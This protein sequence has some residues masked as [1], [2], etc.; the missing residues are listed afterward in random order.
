MTNSHFE[1]GK[2]FH[3]FVQNFVLEKGNISDE[4][5]RK[6][7][8]K[9]PDKSRGSHE[10]NCFLVSPF[11]TFVL[12]SKPRSFIEVTL[13][14]TKRA[15]I[16]LSLPEKKKFVVIEIKTSMGSLENIEEQFYDMLM[17]TKKYSKAIKSITGFQAIETIYLSRYGVWISNNRQKKVNYIKII[18]EPEHL[19]Q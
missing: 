11:A 14:E 15:D 3:R 1:Y 16:I 7:I 12:N 9:S 13:M 2:W 18:Q 19:F 4:I 5:I 6:E 10:V 17:Q 8:K